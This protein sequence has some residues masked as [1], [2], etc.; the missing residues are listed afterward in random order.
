MLGCVT[1]AKLLKESASLD[2][3]A[4]ELDDRIHELKRVMYEYAWHWAWIIGLSGFAGGALTTWI[5]GSYNAYLGAASV[6]FCSLAS[7]SQL[8]LRHTREIDA[9]SAKLS[10]IEAGITGE[11]LVTRELLQLPESYI[12]INDV[13]V[14]AGHSSTQIDHVVVC[15]TGSI[16]CIETKHWNGTFYPEQYGWRRAHTLTWWDF[17]K[18]IRHFPYQLWKD[19]REQSVYH[20]KHVAE[21]LRVAGYAVNAIPVVVLTHKRS[22]YKGLMSFDYCP[23]LYRRDIKKYILKLYDRASRDISLQENV[24]DVL[25]STNSI[26]DASRVAA[27]AGYLEMDQ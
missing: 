19:P 5:Y 3:V 6:V 1:L 4:D 24:V 22:R 25:L 13:R 7:Y 11:E 23:V 20:A 8:V 16:V 10:L 17:L 9:I 21:L 27:A 2:Q 15:P 14:P 12:V 26:V 18:G